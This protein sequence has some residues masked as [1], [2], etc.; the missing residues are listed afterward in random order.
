MF[1]LQSERQ[2]QEPEQGEKDSHDETPDASSTHSLWLGDVLDGTNYVKFTHTSC[3]EENDHKSEH[4]PHGVG[5][6]QAADGEMIHQLKAHL[7]KGYGHDLYH[8]PTNQQTEAAPNSGSYKRIEDPLKGEQAD[9][10][11]PLG[12]YSSR[13][14]QFLFPFCSQHDEDKKDEQDAGNDRETAEDEEHGGE[15]G[16]SLIGII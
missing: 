7:F 12:A 5:Y 3:R 15:R 4:H 14:A 9:D 2:Q 16:T 8:P 13:Y 10:V 6:H 1:C 11:P